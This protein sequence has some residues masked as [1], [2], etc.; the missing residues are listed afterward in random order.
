MPWILVDIQ[1]LDSSI[2]VTFLGY[3]L[4]VDMCNMEL[5]EKW[6]MKS[7]QTILVVTGEP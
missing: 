1:F 3:K 5:R 2:P 7:I 4:I 6:P